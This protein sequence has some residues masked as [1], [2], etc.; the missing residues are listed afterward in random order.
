M[1]AGYDGM[2][3]FFVD[4]S[5]VSDTS[6]SRTDLAAAAIA[7]VSSRILCDYA[8]VSSLGSYS[9]ICQVRVYTSLGYKLSFPLSCQL[10]FA[11]PALFYVV[12]VVELLVVTMALHESLSLILSYGSQWLDF[13][14]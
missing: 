14:S 4:I 5:P 2:S 7:F 3:V 13:P 9:H 10:T 11:P 12:C 6:S 1:C 8:S